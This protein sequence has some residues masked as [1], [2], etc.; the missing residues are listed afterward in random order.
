MARA[1]CH[2]A[3]LRVLRRRDTSAMGDGP[4]LTGAAGPTAAG[5]LLNLITGSPTS[6]DMSATTP[7]R[8]TVLGELPA[9]ME[10]DLVV[11]DIRSTSLIDFRM[12]FARDFAEQL[13][14]HE[15]AARVTTYFPWCEYCV[16]THNM[17]AGPS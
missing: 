7:S 9:G 2:I 12:S 14:I 10:A 1:L 11:L 17:V 6:P 8:P 15:P 3:R 16:P 13:F 4:R 5:H